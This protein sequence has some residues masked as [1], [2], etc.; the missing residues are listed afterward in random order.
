LRVISYSPSVVQPARLAS[1]SPRNAA[2][3]T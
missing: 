2:F 1:P 3:R